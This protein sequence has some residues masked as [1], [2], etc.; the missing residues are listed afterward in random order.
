M[1]EQTLDRTSAVQHTTTRW[2]IGR[3]WRT[4]S[5]LPLGKP[6]FS[7][8]VGRSARYTGTIGGRVEALGSGY[9][10]VSLRDRAKVR[11]HLDSVH[12]IALINLGEMATGLSL[13]EQ[14]DGRGRGILTGIRMRY[15]RKAR[16]TITAEAEYL[17]P[18]LPGKHEISVNGTLK[19]ASGAVVA[20]VTA[21]WRVDIFP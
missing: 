19:D 3:I 20:E 15:L 17:A 4:L 10:K 8:L 2:P 7:W 21:D 12:A 9:C 11:N 6:V 13:I 1:Q 14:I 16:G 5:G 18:E